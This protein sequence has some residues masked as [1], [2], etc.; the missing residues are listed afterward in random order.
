M[1]I[2]P[3]LYPHMEASPP[4]E[5]DFPAKVK[6]SEIHAGSSAN[7]LINSGEKLRDGDGFCYIIIRL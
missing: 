5:G 2:T 7:K 6:L 4:A 1:G 3:A